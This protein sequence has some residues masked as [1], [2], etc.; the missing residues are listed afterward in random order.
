M[1]PA[2]SEGGAVE[3]HLRPFHGGS[4]NP[5]WAT[6]GRSYLAVEYGVR[7][8]KEPRLFSCR[9]FMAGFVGR[10]RDFGNHIQASKKIS[11]TVRGYLPALACGA[12]LNRSGTQIR[13]RP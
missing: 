8:N 5:V 9:R 2:R 13:W 11:G 7:L 6:L 4:Q 10:G 3:S 12:G 1:S